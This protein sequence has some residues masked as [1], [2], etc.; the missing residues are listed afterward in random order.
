M[1]DEVSCQAPLR[2]PLSVCIWISDSCN[3]S[4]KYCYA[5]P[6]SGQMI[7]AMR[8]YKVLD[9]LID[10]KVFGIVLAGGEPFTHPDCHDIIEYCTSRNVQLGVLSNGSLLDRASIARLDAMA[11]GKKFILQISLDSHIPGINDKTR[12]CGARVIENLK[13]LC[14]T[15]IRLQ[16]ATVVTKHNAGIAH[17][18]IGMFYPRIKRFH[19]LNVQRTEQSLKHPDML[20]AGEEAKEFWLGLRDYSRQYPADL[21]LPSLR[22]MLRAAKEEDS[23]E[24]SEFH[25]QATFAC[26]TC[27]VG[28]THINIDSDFNVLG[29]D[30]AKDFSIMGNVRQRS[31]S[32]VWH[33][34]R[35]HHIR[36]L[37]FP[38]CYKNKSPEGESLQD[39]LREEYCHLDHAVHMPT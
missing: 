29:C 23:P 11:K 16:L 30:I 9:E 25:Q 17:Q 27:S 37:P 12:G 39:S 21:F 36:N 32:E 22:I 8:L 6:F 28:L 1:A 5:K 26:R 34:Q 10:L 19:F 24:M 20:L 7:D 3:L 13:A 33:S 2:A 18:V 4:C 31:F 14:E 15:D 38:P 35:A